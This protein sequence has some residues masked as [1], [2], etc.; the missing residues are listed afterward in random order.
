MTLNRIAYVINAFPQL[1]E[2][3]IAEEIAEVLRRGISIKIFSLRPP[4]EQKFH[5]IIYEA[6]LLER[7][8]YGQEHFQ[9]T[10]QAFQPDLIHAHFAT[11]ATAAARELAA[12]I[13]VPFTFTA[14]R[15]DI[16]SK[17]PPDFHER[18]MAAASVVTVSDMNIDYMSETFG[19]PKNHIHLIPC[20]VD[21]QR[22]RP[23]GSKATPPHI[24]CVARLKPFKNQKILLEAC[25]ELKARGRKFHCILVGEG[26]T[27]DELDVLRSRLGLEGCLDLVGG[28]VQSEVLK[29]WQRA[30]I[31][32]LPSESE[33][34]PVC[35][36][37][38]AAC[39]L[40]IVATA[41]GGV[42]EMIQEGVT[43]FLTPSGSA[44]SLV[45]ALEKLLLN[46]ELR[47]KMGNKAREGAVAQFSV[48]RQVNQLLSL[49]TNILE[50]KASQ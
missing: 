31:A 10:L 7:T 49:W 39:G 3:F 41:V 33:G 40:P 30:S 15:Y 19:V 17:A 27:R 34:M 16:Y 1:S 36:M 32:V 28:A 35:L 43:G 38:A 44:T 23:S 6:G 37:E 20:G 8:V 12:D 29:W 47:E 50:K 22:F 2:T 24:V 21:T 4:K 25:A 48:V 11:K 13:D 14:H 5:E 9:K 18:A 46:P 42:P 45:T 26:P